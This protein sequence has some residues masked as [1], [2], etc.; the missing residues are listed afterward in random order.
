MVIATTIKKGYKQTELGVIPEVWDARP[1]GDFFDFKN[2]L[3]KAKGFF[4]YGKPIV[5]YMDVYKNREMYSKNIHGRVDVNHQ[6]IK[7]FNV[8]KGDV[9]FTRTSETVKEI[10]ITSVLLDDLKNGVFSGFILRARSTNND[11]EDFYKKYCFSPERVRKQIQEKSTYTTRALTNGRVLSKVKIFYPP[12][13]EQHAIA[14]I[15]SDT[16]ALIDHLEKLIAKKKNI[17]QGAMQQLLTGKKRLPGFSGEWG[18]KKLGEIADFYKGKGLPKSEITINGKYKCIHYGE[19]FTTYHE[20]INEIFSYT[21]KK[22]DF[23][24]SHTN[25]VLMPTSDVTPNGLAT[26]S[27]V[28]EDEVILGSDVLVIRPFDGVLDGVFLSYGIRQNKKQIMQLVSGSTVYHLYGS[29]MKKYEFSIPST[30][31]EQIAIATILSDMDA[32]IEA[33]EQKRDK[34]TMIKQGMMQQL[35]TGRIRVHDID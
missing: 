3:N 28:K 26:A 25:D 9:F 19:L 13:Q 15:L 21:N 11:L 2:G 18:V 16:D 23:F 7:S 5:N 31:E 1:I 35:L 24:H 22:D 27:C 14:T 12:K 6:E 33:L 32:E 30:I 34:Y 4:G 17:K 20:K 8:K 10:G 29:D